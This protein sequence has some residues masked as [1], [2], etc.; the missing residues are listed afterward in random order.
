MTTSFKLFCSGLFLSLGIAC[1]QITEITPSDYFKITREPNIVEALAI[2]TLVTGEETMQ[3]LQ[4]HQAHIIFQDLR[5]FG[6]NY[7]NDDALTLVNYNTQQQVIYIN[8]RH[9]NA[10]APAL[11]ALIR[12]ES[13]HSDNSNSIREETCAWTMEAKTWQTMT[14]AYPKL[15]T[16]AIKDSPLVD[17]LKAIVILLNTNRLAAHIHQNPGYQGLPPY[18]PGFDDN[19]LCC[20]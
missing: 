14:Q 7:A 17:R 4:A 8:Q 5:G 3:S 19:S 15:T 20:F 10:P 2:L 11:A 16:L 13:M 1:A 9:Q 18:S 12:H 6:P